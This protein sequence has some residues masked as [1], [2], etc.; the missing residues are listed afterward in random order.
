MPEL[1]LNVR[2]S[3]KGTNVRDELSNIALL[4]GTRPVRNQYDGGLSSYQKK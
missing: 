3:L 4:D 1:T 2:Q